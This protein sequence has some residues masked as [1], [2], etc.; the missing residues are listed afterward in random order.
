[1]ANSR[2]NLNKLTTARES[3]KI[4][5]SQ[6]AYILG[7]ADGAAVFAPHIGYADGAAELQYSKNHGNPCYGG[8]LSFLI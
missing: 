6:L 3:R 4:P 2:D 7:Y 5:R 1:M 8:D